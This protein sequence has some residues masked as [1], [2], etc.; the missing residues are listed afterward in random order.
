[1]GTSFSGW[2]MNMASCLLHLVCIEMVDLPRCEHLPPF[3][4]LKNLEQLT[5]RAS[6][7]VSHKILPQNYVLGA[8]S[9]NF[10]PKIY[11]S[12]ADH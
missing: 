9:K 2:M 10:P 11:Q 1:M 5:L 8:I 4:Q 7:R 3:G 6:P 12:T